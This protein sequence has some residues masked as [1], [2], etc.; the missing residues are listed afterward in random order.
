[1][2]K[3]KAKQVHVNDVLSTIP[4]LLCHDF[5][6]NGFD[7][8]SPLQKVTQKKRIEKLEMKGS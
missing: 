4:S 3:T 8:N 5:G 7:Q 1:M 2:K 6:E